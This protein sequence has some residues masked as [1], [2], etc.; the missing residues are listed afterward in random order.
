M[1]ELFFNLPVLFIFDSPQDWL[2]VI[3]AVALLFG[4]NKLPEFAR[5]IGKTRKAFKEGMRE[6]DEAESQSVIRPAENKAW[7]SIDDETLLKEIS[8]RQETRQI[9]K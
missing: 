9:E 3:A 1:I 6:A 4:A 2:V 8:R 5:S 7:A